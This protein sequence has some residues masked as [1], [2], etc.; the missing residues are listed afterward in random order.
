[1]GYELH[2]TRRKDWSA[3][4][5]DISSG[6][7]LA[8]AG[9]DPELSLTAESGPYF[10]EWR[11]PSAQPGSWLDWETGTVFTK[12]ADR[13]MLAKMIQVATALHARVQ[14]DDGEIYTSADAPPEFPS[15]TMLQR[16]SRWIKSLRPIATAK[17]LTPAEPRFQVGERVHDLYYREAT[18][19]AIDPRSNHGLGSVRIRYDDG[20]EVAFA[21]AASGL[22]SLNQTNPPA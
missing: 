1:M 5:D 17:P 22:S 4:G 13:A 11:N 8:Y 2:I 9:R 6:E 14:G 19:V 3:A 18:V 7:W 20:R 21:L 12:G 15:P 16:F 10:T